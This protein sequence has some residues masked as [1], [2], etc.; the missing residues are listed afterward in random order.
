M[1]NLNV[2]S[3]FDFLNSNIRIEDLIQK[4]ADDGQPAVALTDFNRM[5]GIY[6]FMQTAGK[7]GIKPL[8]GM[9]IRISDGFGTAIVLIAKNDDGFRELIRLS[10]MLS[11]KDITET[12]LN[13]LIENIRQCLVIAKDDEGVPVLDA[14]DIKYE[15][16][17]QSHTV[18]SN[19]YNR[20]FLQTSYYLSETDLPA[21]RVL[22]AIRDNERI[23]IGNV[24]GEKGQCHVKTFHD[25]T[26][27]EKEILDNNS[28]LLSK[29]NVSIPKTENILP[30]FL[31]EQGMNSKEYLWY[32][33]KVNLSETADAGEEY[34]KR[35]EYEYNIIIEMGYEDYFL[36]VQDAVNF[37]KKSGI[38]VG[39]GRGSSSAS[40]VSYLLNITEV[41]PLKYNLLFERFL[42]PERVSMPDIDIDFEDTRR[43]EVVD[44]L[45]GKYGAMNVSHIITYGTLS[46]KMAARDVGRVFGFSDEELK[47][48]SN[49]IPDT[50]GVT[51]ED[52]FESDKFQSLVAT[53]DKYRTFA[54]ICIKIEGLPR[55]SSTHAAGVLLSEDTLTK[56][57]PV[58]FQE[59]RALS[60]WTMTE[61]E[62]AGLLKIDVLGLRNLSLIRYM[63]NRIEKV[64]PDFDYQD[65]P[66]DNP[67]VYRML[68]KG[69]T[70]G[71]FQLESDG[72]RRVIQDVNPENFMDLASVIALYRPGP[73]KEIPH[74]I[75]GK[76]NPD[77]V[78]YPHPDLEDIL[79]ET[80]GVIVYQEQIMQIASKIAG[81]TY[82]RADILR[83]AM[84][85]KDRQTLEKERVT[86]ER[87]AEEK[88]YGK[89]L[90][91]FIFDLIM[92]FAD[93]GFAKSHAVAYSRISYTL[94]FIKTMYPEIFYSVILTH[95]FGNDVKTKQVTDEIRQMRI[96]ILPPDINKSEWMNISKEGV[97]LGF[98]M[99]K[100]VTY[101][102]AEAIIEERKNG[103][104]KD[105]Y[106]LK[107]RV[108]KVNLN[109][110][111]LRHLI[112]SG[113]LDDFDENRKTML[114]S[115]PLID[116]LNTD[117]YSHDS[118]LSTLGFSVKKEFNHTEEMDSVEMIE[119]EKEVFGFYISEHPIKLKHKELQY[120]PFALLYQK[121]KNAKYLL[122]FESVKTIKT[123][124][125]QNM[126]FAR[127]SDGLEEVE[128][129]IF[130][131]TYFNVHHLLN[132][133]ILVVS[134]RIEDRKGESQLIAEDI[135]TLDAFKESYMKSARHVFIRNTGMYELS[136]ILS[137]EGMTVMDFDSRREIGKIARGNIYS[138]INAVNS[139]DIRILQ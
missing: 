26:A 63:I 65:I 17:Y 40:L 69:L 10:A 112:I 129:V 81:Y 29:C 75:Q 52:V 28:K 50:P 134:G 84:S 109:K 98:S 23:E 117:E 25:L 126:A 103:A 41:D 66:E 119:G 70:L 8:A 2:H 56:V 138:L 22:N 61:V 85:K 6:R 121:K 108:D 79:K 130:P 106:D 18:S 30:H 88:G 128:A 48:I 132:E 5:H 39:P 32:L 47:L 58:I 127:V 34:M 124:K 71:V 91:K 93:Y 16:K 12:P 13:Y 33:L 135:E 83:R 133:R 68:A 45:M 46:A 136:G 87:G 57:V 115:L 122:F 53:N 110:K 14:L 55:H 44:Y 15:D 36:I 97:R 21:V 104:F 64:N 76:E 131:K 100:G 94:G 137:D 35:L 4:A 74:F 59:G 67:A 82:A 19:E 62:A 125:G 118:F 49:L 72:I 114:Q 20:L 80:Y 89:K 3:C 43:D 37:A 90:G 31:N 105:I 99:V 11:Y 51:L 120:I 78:S 42:N 27:E 77:S 123:K 54:E 96:S 113:A 101:R 116:S 139:H 111:I 95:H 7:N 107:T 60:Q 24:S 38:Y 92:E 102:T 9:E 86:F 1:I 73:M